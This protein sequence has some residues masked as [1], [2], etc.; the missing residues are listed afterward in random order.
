MPV[1][2]RTAADHSE[3]TRLSDATAERVA[4]QLGVDPDG[5]DPQPIR[6]AD[7]VRALQPL[8]SDN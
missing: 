3:L 2:V 1:A 7:L 8:L 5:L 6:A 4:R